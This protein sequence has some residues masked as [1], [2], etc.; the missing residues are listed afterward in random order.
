MQGEVARVME[1]GFRPPEQY[2]QSSG[3]AAV[4]LS[5]SVALCDLARLRA[6]LEAQR[7]VQT[8]EGFRPN[9]ALHTQLLITKVF[10]AR[11]AQEKPP[12]VTGEEGPVK[13]ANYEGF[14][15]VYRSR[16]PGFDRASLI[17]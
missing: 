12:R 16:R 13:A 6:A 7:G 3:H 2:L 10:L 4:S 8:K 11:C 15:S 1:G 17:A 14:S 9:E 5:N